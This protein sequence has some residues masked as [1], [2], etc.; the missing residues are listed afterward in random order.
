M[1]L[2]F[3]KMHPEFSSLAWL[4]H[5][6]GASP[7]RVNIDGIIKVEDVD[8]VIHCISTD[9]H[10]MPIVRYKE[11]CPLEIGYYKIIKKSKSDLILEQIEIDIYPNWK[12][13]IPADGL[14]KIERPEREFAFTKETHFSYLQSDIYFMFYNKCCMN[15]KWLEDIGLF[16][17][18][19]W[20]VHHNDSLVLFHG[21][22]IADG[23]YFKFSLLAMKI[24]VPDYPE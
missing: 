16:F 19:G 17:E 11:K 9:M 5:N 6:V 3:N 2:H 22:H 10:R 18:T 7:C 14:K 12:S 15:Y 1:A 4:C 8:G 20:E 13:V 24:R 23:G 21:K